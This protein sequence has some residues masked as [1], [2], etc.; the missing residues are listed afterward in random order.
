[1]PAT[2]SS[3]LCALA[4]AAP[5]Q[6]GIRPG[7]RPTTSRPRSSSSAPRPAP[8]TAAFRAAR[9]APGSRPDRTGTSLLM[10]A[11]SSRVRAFRRSL[12]YMGEQDGEVMILARAAATTP[13]PRR[14]APITPPARHARS[15]ACAANAAARTCARRGSDSSDGL[16][17]A[18]RSP[19]GPCGNSAPS[20]PR[21]P[22]ADTPSSAWPSKE[23]ARLPKAFAGAWARPS[24]TVPDGMAGGAGGQHSL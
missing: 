9:P 14:P 7:G 3:R 12:R 18:S 4:E 8:R 1:M 11:M 10:A 5:R 23:L 17:N 20:P 21:A 16:R 24:L 22:R 19:G 15:A 13:W 6:A 2:R